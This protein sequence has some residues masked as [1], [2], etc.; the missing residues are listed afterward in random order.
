M[1]R[2]EGK[3]LA[4]KQL[5]ACGDLPVPCLVFVQS[6]ERACQ[7][8]EELK[9]EKLHVDVVTAD[10]PQPQRDRI[11]MKLR[12]GL[13]WILV[14][15]DLMARG[16]D[17]KGVNCVINFDFPQTISQYIHRIGRTG[18]AGHPGVA[19]TF[20][21]EEDSPN[22]RMIANVIKKSGGLVPDWILNLPKISKKRRKI[23]AVR[24]PERKNISNRPFTKKN[25]KNQKTL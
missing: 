24:P 21:T 23:F 5:I 16:M 14:T 25:E 22:L 1:G 6:K 7:L 18:R 10:R 13:I 2:E 15:T 17:F 20:F 19:I 4:L 11:V 9:L 8:N 3:V 12:M